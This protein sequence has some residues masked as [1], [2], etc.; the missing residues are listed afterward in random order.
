MRH[1]IYLFIIIYQTA[2]RKI[3][4]KEIALMFLMK[5]HLNLGVQINLTL[6]DNKIIILNSLGLYKRKIKMI[7]F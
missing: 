3:Q 1:E 7:L 4:Y 6:R 5:I 2:Y